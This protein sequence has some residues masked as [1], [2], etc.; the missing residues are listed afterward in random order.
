M[1]YIEG[2]GD[3]GIDCGS[4]QGKGIAIGFYFCRTQGD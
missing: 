1:S 3:F 2:L 4:A